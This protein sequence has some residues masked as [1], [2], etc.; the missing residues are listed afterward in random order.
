MPGG[1]EQQVPGR[2][3][4][5]RCRLLYQVQVCCAQ[6]M[7]N[8][9]NKSDDFQMLNLKQVGNCLRGQRPADEPD[10]ERERG[11][12]SQLDAA[13]REPRRPQHLQLRLEL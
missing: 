5:A 2:D 3:Q 1:A 7:E 6:Q 10:R 13:C 11:G 9:H 8:N 4:V 12:C